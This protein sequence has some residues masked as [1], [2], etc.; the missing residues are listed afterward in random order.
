MNINQKTVPED[1]HLKYGY[2]RQ[3]ENVCMGVE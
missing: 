3:P 1:N 2:N